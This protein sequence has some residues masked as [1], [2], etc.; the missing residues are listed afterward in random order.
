MKIFT[1]ITVLMLAFTV[2]GCQ[3]EA[4]KSVNSFDEVVEVE[5]R[6]TGGS[7]MYREVNFS[8]NGVILDESYQLK[9]EHIK[10]SLIKGQY[11]SVD[12]FQVNLY[13]QNGNI[14]NEMTV[15]VNINGK[16][17]DNQ[18]GYNGVLKYKY[19]NE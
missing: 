7:E 11:V 14:Y 8:T 1:I 13:G 16:F 10:V 12:G 17:K 18:S 3:K 4:V 19:S 6:V 2:G 5:L 15:K 9:K